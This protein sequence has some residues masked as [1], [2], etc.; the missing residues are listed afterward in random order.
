MSYGKS[1]GNDLDEI[2]PMMPPSVVARHKIASALDSIIKGDYNY[3][4]I[5]NIL[6]DIRQDPYIPRYLK[7]EAGYILV[8]VEKIERE[9]RVRDETSKKYNAST[10]DLAETAGK[11]DRCLQENE[12]MKN[13][14]K[15][16]KYKLE[17][18][19]EI[20]IDIEKRR[21]MQ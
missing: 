18:I 2:P 21:G 10:K 1:I 15:E 16:L 12:R 3:K 8:L 19:E 20:H 9:R 5:T 11:Y 6:I 4:D 14:L 7:V 13:E 17:K